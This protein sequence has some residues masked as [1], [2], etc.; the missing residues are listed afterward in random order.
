MKELQLQITK[1]PNENWEITILFAFCGKHK[2]YSTV[3]LPRVAFSTALVDENPS[4]V[5]FIAAERVPD[6][7]AS[8]T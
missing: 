2:N 3:F 1:H 8:R 5:W 7:K 6:W 4:T